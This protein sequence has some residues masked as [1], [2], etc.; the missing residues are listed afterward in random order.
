MKIRLK[1]AWVQSVEKVNL[2]YDQGEGVI[3]YNVTFAFNK[4]EK[5]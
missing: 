2:T 1:Q 3:K 4:W 5:A